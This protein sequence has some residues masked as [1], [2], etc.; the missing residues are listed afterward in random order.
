M[1]K[2]A[3]MQIT[4]W[5]TFAVLKDEEANYMQLT[6]S[7]ELPMADDAIEFLKYMPILFLFHFRKQYSLLGR[8]TKSTSF[9][10]IIL[11]IFNDNFNDLQLVL[12][13]FLLLADAY[14]RYVSS[15]T[16]CT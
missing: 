7:S 14:C 12:E 2:F 5:N 15:C 1:C 3:N 10:F 11:M 4:Y 13:S 16:I 6:E 9:S 8:K